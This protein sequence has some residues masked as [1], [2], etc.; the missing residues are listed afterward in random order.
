MLILKDFA[1]IAGDVTDNTVEYPAYYLN[2]NY[3]YLICE[4]GVSFDSTNSEVMT[5]GG[6]TLD[7]VIV[8]FIIIKAVD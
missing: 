6:S 2:K 1:D 4:T 7:E 8:P 5:H 3:Q